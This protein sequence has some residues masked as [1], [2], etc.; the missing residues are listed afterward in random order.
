MILDARG[1]QVFGSDTLD[2]AVVQI[3][4]GD[5]GFGTGQG[6]G[7]DRVAV[8]LRCDSY[9]AI[10]QVLHWMVAAAV[11][12]LEFER[13]S[14]QSLTEN[15][16]AEADTKQGLLVEQA[17]Y[18]L[19]DRLQPCGVAR[20]WTEK[21]AV[22]IPSQDFVAGSGSGQ[23]DASHADRREPPQ[24]VMLEAAVEDHDPVAIT[25]AGFFDRFLARVAPRIGRLRRHAVHKIGFVIGL[26]LLQIAEGLIG[27]SV[28]DR[29][30]GDSGAAN[31]LG[32]GTG[33]QPLNGHHLAFHEKLVERFRGA[34]VARQIASLADDETRW[35][36][37]VGFKIVFVDPVV[38]DERISKKDDLPGVAG[39][40]Q[41]LLIAGHAG[42]E[43][44]FTGRFSGV[45]E[46]FSLVDRAVT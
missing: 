2:R 40:G 17:L 23:N 20:A 6:I 44:N 19:H 9:A 4:L 5:F 8:V 38:S 27:I 37:P 16:V 32:N 14:A 43:N 24:N 36:K 11:P 1:S 18:G 34:P 42:V 45:S 33:I 41:N 46:R 25:F 15:L 13:L 28:R 7:I 29:A 31:T 26:G 3:D 12:E 22:R 30:H 21:N 10:G 35:L 39:V